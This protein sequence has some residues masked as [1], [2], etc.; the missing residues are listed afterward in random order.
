MKNLIHKYITSWA[1]PKYKRLVPKLKSMYNK[2]ID[3]KYGIK[4]E[5]ITINNDCCHGNCKCESKDVQTKV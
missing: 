3:W 2:F 4:V 5:S 1:I